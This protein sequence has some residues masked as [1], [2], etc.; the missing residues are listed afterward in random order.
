MLEMLSEE[1]GIEVKHLELMSKMLGLDEAVAH[2]RHETLIIAKRAEI[3]A[4][5]T[6]ANDWADF[7][8]NGKDCL[9]VV[10]TNINHFLEDAIKEFLYGEWM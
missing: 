1:T 8:K 6:L 3:C 2:I 7:T 5:Y 9:E 4:E 10:E